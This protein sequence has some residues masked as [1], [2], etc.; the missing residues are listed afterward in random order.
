[1]IEDP[2]Y[3]PKTTP[4]Y[5]IGDFKNMQ[6]Y[7]TS[8]HVE[9]E[10]N[11]FGYKVTRYKLLPHTQYDF[12]PSVVNQ[13]N[14]LNSNIKKI[15]FIS[16]VA[17]WKKLRKFKK[18]SIIINYDNHLIKD[19]PVKHFKD[20]FFYLMRSN[21]LVGDPNHPHFNLDKFNNYFLQPRTCHLLYDRICKEQNSLESIEQFIYN[22]TSERYKPHE[23]TYTFK[24]VL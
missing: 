13:F 15:N 19:I 4:V 14:S 7:E 23:Q 5:M 8:K 24:Y 3:L 21:S 20:P 18:P 2:L 16:H 17:L 11:K 12:F 10:W 9:K 22:I 6:V 1:M